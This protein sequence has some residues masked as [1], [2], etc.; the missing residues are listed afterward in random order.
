VKP[1]AIFTEE[2]ADVLTKPSKQSNVSTIANDTAHDYRAK[3][4]WQMR[5]AVV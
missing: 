1:N 4:A 5:H 3:I 2:N